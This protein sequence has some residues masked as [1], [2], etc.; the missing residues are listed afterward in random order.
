MEAQLTS[1]RQGRYP[2]P[3]YPAV[4]MYV[5][6]VLY[7]LQNSGHTSGQTTGS[8]SVVSLTLAHAA[9]CL[10]CRQYCGGKGQTTAT[11]ISQISSGA[12]ANAPHCHQDTQ[13]SNSS[14][15]HKRQSI[16]LCGPIQFAEF[17][18]LL[19]IVCTASQPHCIYTSNLRFLQ[20]NPA[21]PKKAAIEK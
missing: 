1:G 10:S 15:V 5:P 17:E 19:H 9:V 21:R 16:L 3:A 13:L 18:F 2:G 14:N 12:I 8:W 11:C 7:I 20:R 6:C 4:C